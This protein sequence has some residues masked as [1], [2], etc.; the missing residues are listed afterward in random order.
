MHFPRRPVWMNDPDMAK[1]MFTEVKGKT[2]L[3]IVEDC[4]THS[5]IEQTFRTPTDRE[6]GNVYFRRYPNGDLDFEHAKNLVV[7][8]LKKHKEVLS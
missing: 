1:S 7:D 6:F 4:P 5:K 3:T 8:A 2:D